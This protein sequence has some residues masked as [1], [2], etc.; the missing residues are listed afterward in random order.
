MKLKNPTDHAII[1]HK[2]P[3]KYKTK[4]MLN[5]FHPLDASC[6]SKCVLPPRHALHLSGGRDVIGGVTCND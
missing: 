1:V 6:V 4:G 2:A 3:V 5:Y